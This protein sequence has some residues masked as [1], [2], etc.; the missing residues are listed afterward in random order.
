M[1]Q[2]VGGPATGRITGFDW[3]IGL[4]FQR[5]CFNAFRKSE[6]DLKNRSI[7]PLFE[8]RA[9]N[10]PHSCA[11]KRTTH[12]R[13]SPKN[14]RTRRSIS[15]SVQTPSAIISASFLEI[16][17]GESMARRYI[18]GEREKSDGC[19]LANQSRRRRANLREAQERL[20]S[21]NTSSV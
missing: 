17:F 7:S 5:F 15:S 3:A 14:F 9:A 1:F 16:D 4:I 19:G 18:D 20:V 12:L 2:V 8:R 13:R 11:A 10:S 6:S 21:E